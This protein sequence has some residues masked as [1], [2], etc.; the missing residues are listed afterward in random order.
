[1]LMVLEVKFKVNRMV[2]EIWNGFIFRF[3]IL[4][5]LYLCDCFMWIEFGEGCI[6][7][8]NFDW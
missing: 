1:M 8:V 3:C 2:V 5:F 4:V 6:Y 7:W